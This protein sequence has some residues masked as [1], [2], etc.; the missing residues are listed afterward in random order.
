M[1]AQDVG[2]H[3]YIRISIKV[4]VVMTVTG[5]VGIRAICIFAIRKLE[6]LDGI[7]AAAFQDGSLWHE[8]RGGDDGEYN[9]DGKIE[10]MIM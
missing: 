2:L 4:L 7:I 10:P 1:R 6:S 9:D 8:R 5:S 3:A